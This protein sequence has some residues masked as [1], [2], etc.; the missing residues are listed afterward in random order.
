MLR[1]EDLINIKYVPAESEISLNLLFDFYE[2]H[3]CKRVYKFTLDDG[4][5]IKI[6]FK[7]T[8][9]IYHVSGIKHLYR[10]NYMDGSRFAQGV[11]NGSIDFTS[12]QKLNPNAYNDY[13]ERIRSFACIDTIIKNC[14]YLWF[15]N[16]KIDD[17]DILVKYLLL[18]AVAEYN[19]HLGI[20]TYNKGKTYYPKTLLVTKGAQKNK[21]LDKASS[22]FRVS[23]LE[24][25]IKET[26]QIEEVIYRKMAWDKAKTYIQKELDQWLQNEFVEKIKLHVFSKDFCNLLSED[27]TKESTSDEVKQAVFEHIKRKQKDEWIS[28]L[29]AYLD[30]RKESLKQL[31]AIHDPYWA[32]KIA[33]ES[34]QAFSRSEF[35]CM[36]EEA[37]ACYVNT[38][39]ESIK[40]KVIAN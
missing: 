15:S 13:S 5:E 11:C 3:L 14:E 26:N 30:S 36:V 35:K 6:T 34:I 8:S 31:V 39:S 7:D 12:L 40:A 4:Q 37:M 29:R 23:K 20:D 33:S 1:I 10:G 21:F 27:I 17:T 18:K 38:E 25:I 22:K 32:G 2:N 24:I 16:G 19:L 9:E 28:M